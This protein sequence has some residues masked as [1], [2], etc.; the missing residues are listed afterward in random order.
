MNDQNRVLG[1]WG[2]RSLT[3]EELQQVGGGLHTD[4]VCTVP[5]EV[6]PNKDGDASIGECGPV[7]S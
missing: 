5:T 7:C 4:T 6:C 1:R 3:E 2:A